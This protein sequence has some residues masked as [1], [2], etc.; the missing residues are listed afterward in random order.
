M[1][2]L[3]ESKPICNET[4]YEKHVASIVGHYFR[5]QRGHKL[6]KP[7]FLLND[8]LRYWRTLCLNYERT[9]NDP[10]KPWRKKNI[11]LKFSR[12]L[13]VFGSVLPLI[14]IPVKSPNG[15]IELISLTPL[16]RLAR[17]LD[18]LSDDNL[19]DDFI[20]FL[21]DY[22]T[23]LQWKEGPDVEKQMKKSKKKDESRSRAVRFSDFLL[24]AVSHRSISEEYRKYLVI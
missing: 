9:R 18:S 6:F 3:L 21:D 5:D 11:N 2:L 22:E 14:S 13:T 24:R 12:M 17:G 1:L 8:V 23:F 20:Q 15:V 19:L 16:E 7:L 10:D 4:L